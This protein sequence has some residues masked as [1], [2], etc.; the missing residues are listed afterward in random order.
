MSMTVSVLN[1]IPNDAEYKKTYPEMRGRGNSGTHELHIFLSE[2]NPSQ[3]R[4]KTYYQA[5][6]DWNKQ[7]P[8]ITDKMKACYLALVFRSSD[9]SE[10]TVKVMQSARYLRSD[11]TDQVVKECHSDADFFVKHSF[12]VIREKIEATAH[13]ID[14]I[15]Q[16]DAETQTHKT[17]YFELHI[18]V[19][20]KDAGDNTALNE[21][22]IEQ[23]K[24]ISRQFTSNFG[25]PIPLSYNCNQDGISGDGLGHQRFLNVRFRDLGMSSIKPKLDEINQAITAVGL[26][27]IKT[28]SEYVWYDSFT[29]LDHGW[30][31]YTPEEFAKITLGQQ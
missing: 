2:L 21:D 29:Q 14:G 19:G 25:T 12:S 18:K 23:L 15:P 11:D 16:T 5:V 7:H 31:D 27:V 26:R 8:E 24:A 28:I 3:E 9:G 22:E 6:N 20:H 13:G 30:I 1:R 10:N 4:V 17:K